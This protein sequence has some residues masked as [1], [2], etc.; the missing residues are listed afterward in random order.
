MGGRLPV[1]ARKG[2]PFWSN[3]G[4]G[5]HQAK[6]WMQAGYHVVEV[7]L[8]AEVVTFSRPVLRYEIRRVKGSIL[9]N[10][11]M[12]QALR[13]HMDV[14]QSGLAEILGVRQQ[15]VSEWETGLY[16]P[17]R[18][19]S[20]HLTMVAERADFVFGESDSDQESSP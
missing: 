14:N 18:A 17:T 5:A 7:D 3:R 2:K 1:S 20:K 11:P 16:K 8:A 4:S 19:R 15:T 13:V 10:G 6:A 9:W 12:I